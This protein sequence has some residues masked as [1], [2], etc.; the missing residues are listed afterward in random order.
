LIFVV[1]YAGL[2]LDKVPGLRMDLA[3]ITAV[4]ATITR[5]PFL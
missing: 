4:G 2:T 5:C 3:G 1:T